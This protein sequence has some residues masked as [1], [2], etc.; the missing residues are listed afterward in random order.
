MGM[1]IFASGA[2]GIAES[3]EYIRQFNLDYVVFGTSR[4]KNV[5]NNLE[6]LKRA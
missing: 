6:L 5:V 2:G 1:S 3:I 4:V